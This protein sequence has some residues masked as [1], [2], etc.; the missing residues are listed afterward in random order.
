MPLR[1][2][3]AEFAS[4]MK[5][6]GYEQFLARGGGWGSLIASQLAPTTRIACSV[7]TSALLSP[8]DNA[9]ST[10]PLRWSKSARS[11][12]SLLT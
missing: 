1:K 10:T 5:S 3:A 12:G 4:L 9:M 2:I 11:R 6:L 8:G 7:F